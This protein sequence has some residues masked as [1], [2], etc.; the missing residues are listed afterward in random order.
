M[1]SLSQLALGAAVGG[2]VAGRRFGRKALLWGALCGTLPDLDV[3]VPLGDPVSDFTYHR[4]AS[5]SLLMQLLAT[6]LLT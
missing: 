4:S 2:A 5:H 6:P 1:D 3:L